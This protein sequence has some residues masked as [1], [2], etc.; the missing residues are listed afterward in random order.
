MLLTRGIYNETHYHFL[1]CIINLLA[2]VV[3]V[4]LV[5][6]DRIGNR[7]RGGADPLRIQLLQTD[8]P[9]R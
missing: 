8:T 1:C 3:A 4:F 2:K 7:T 9:R 5:L 6:A